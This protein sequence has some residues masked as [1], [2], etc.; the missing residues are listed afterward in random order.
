VPRQ[1][2]RSGRAADPQATVICHHSSSRSYP[3]S[4][5]AFTSARLRPGG[6]GISCVPGRVDLV[7][8][9][10]ILARNRSDDRRTSQNRTSGQLPS[11]ASLPRTRLAR[12][13]CV[14]GV[15]RRI[16]SIAA[17]LLLRGRVGR[18]DLNRVLCFIRVTIQLA[19]VALMRTE[20]TSLRN[21]DVRV[22][23]TAVCGAWLCCF[24][25]RVFN[26]DER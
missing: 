16:G 3:P 12:A 10:A 14:S 20:A 26:T 13:L 2:G 11:R 25:R 18:R 4:P 19:E 17:G 24:G 22:T 21:S 1:G 6:A 5:T 8:Q 15:F 7:A 23:A 9:R